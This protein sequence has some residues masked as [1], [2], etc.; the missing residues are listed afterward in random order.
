MKGDS[1]LKTQII[2]LSFLC[3]VFFCAIADSPV[4]IFENGNFKCVIA[5]AGDAGPVI[6]AASKELKFYLEKIGKGKVD[7]IK[8]DKSPV[9]SLAEFANKKTVI[10]IGDNYYVREKGID[11]QSLP[12][13][14]FVI[15]TIPE[16]LIIAGKDD[17]VFSYNYDWVPGS[18]GTLYGVYRFLEKLGCRWYLPIPIGE[19]IPQRPSLSIPEINISDAPY[20]EYRFGY[21]HFKWRRQT[22]YGGTV[23]PW[24][25]RHTL[26]Q[27][28]DFVSKYKNT[29]PE[30]FS[31]KECGIALRHPG[32]TEAVA[33]EAISYFDNP[34]LPEGKKYFAVNPSDAWG[35]GKCELCK[36]L[37]VPERGEKGAFSDY[38][39][40]AV[41]DV[42][43][44]VKAKGINYPIVYCAY[45][46][47]LLPPENIKVLPDNVVVLFS[48]GPKWDI[49]E[50]WGKL[51]PKRFYFCF[52]SQFLC[53]LTPTFIPHTIAHNIKTMKEFRESGKIAIGGEMDFGNV[54]EDSPYLWWFCLNEYVTGKLLWNPDLDVDDILDEFYTNFFGPEAAVPM[55]KFFTRLENLYENQNE[56]YIH[57]LK[58]LDEL[59]ALLAQAASAAAGSS[60]Y[61]ARVEYINK[62]FE[63]VRKIRK[64]ISSEN[65]PTEK[66]KP[67]MV[68]SGDE[69][70]FRDSISGKKL[71]SS[72]VKLVD[73][74]NGKAMD[75]SGEKSFVKLPNP[76]LE[77]TDYS[78][79][80]W[81]KPHPVILSKKEYLLGCDSWERHIISLSPK[82]IA[83][84]HRIPGAGY[85]NTLVRLTQANVE[86][87][88]EAWTHLVVA[89]SSE[90]GMAIYINGKLSAIDLTKNRPIQAQ[91]IT[92]L[93]G[94]SGKSGIN[95]LD[96]FWEGAID[97][98]KIYRQ[99]L[100]PEE[101]TDSYNKYPTKQEIK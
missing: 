65:I 25:T 89:F 36:K 10:L 26:V 71:E 88:S 24:S 74:V 38:I 72:G 85:D 33:N 43:Q 29:H 84:Q 20:F 57:S 54:P 61:A 22:G 32:V 8:I 12:G 91:E 69:L 1:N 50:Q 62:S 37:E 96:G 16:G 82:S 31:P 101:I 41:V 76:H 93:L 47:Y 21:G 39:A 7:I 27:T 66:A 3:F 30:Y 63:P 55:K 97:E 79:E 95:D 59:D 35:G 28:V 23:D 92:Y 13:D 2:V 100:S 4:M 40:G 77:Q 81:I 73:G 46:K 58:S 80:M 49:V 14:G 78:I 18:A 86:F 9:P 56:R 75:F 67:V 44:R 34:K 98:V 70:P 48:G 5:V 15:K 11:T 6:K 64:K 53:K 99:E 42:A 19:I 90:N 52:Y 60:E 94:A 17:S 45:E 87:K 68:I 83:F 51:Q